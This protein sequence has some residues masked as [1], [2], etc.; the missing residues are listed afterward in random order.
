VN[1]YRLG[2]LGESIGLRLSMAVTGGVI[3]EL[4]EGEKELEVLSRVT[5]WRTTGRLFTIC[6]CERCVV[7]TFK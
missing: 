5:R 3:V 4:G 1:A 6:E 2:W 7:T